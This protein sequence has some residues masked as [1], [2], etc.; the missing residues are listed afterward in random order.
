MFFYSLSPSGQVVEW[1]VVNL[2]AP[3]RN[4]GSLSPVLP[5][6][7]SQVGTGPLSGLGAAAA[8]KQPHFLL[9]NSS[10]TSFRYQAGKCLLGTLE[11]LASVMR[12][13]IGLRGLGDNSIHFHGHWFVG[14]LSV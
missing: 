3:A 10:Q 11:I 7:R 14:K 12:S 2:E 6:E 8:L 1:N 9:A 13:L 5:M 4:L